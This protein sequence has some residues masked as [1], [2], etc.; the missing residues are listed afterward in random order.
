MA[1][2][3]AFLVGL[4]RWAGRPVL[5]ARAD[6]AVVALLGAVLGLHTLIQA[7]GLRYTSAVNSGWIIAFTPVPIALGGQLL[8]GQRLSTGGWTGVAVA[9]SGIALIVASTTP[10]FAQARTGDALQLASCLTWAVYTLSATGVVARNGSLR[11]TA[12]ATTAGA[13]TLAAATGWSGVLSGSPTGRSLA[14]VAFLGVV[15]GGIGYYL[16]YSALREHGAARIGSYLYLEPFVTVVTSAA[17]LDEPITAPVVGGGVLVLIGVWAV[18]RGT[19]A[20]EP[21]PGPA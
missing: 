4:C 3:A 6:L 21:R 19:R 15:C 16:W 1:V 10:G 17:L 14:A 8:L 9:T 18:A 12:P 2:A 11:V 7:F 20:P 5:P 13:A